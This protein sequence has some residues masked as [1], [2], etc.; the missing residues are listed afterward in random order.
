MEVKGHVSYPEPLLKY[1]SE[2]R[3]IGREMGEVTTIWSPLKRHKERGTHLGMAEN[4]LNIWFLAL[5]GWRMPANLPGE[6][7]P[8]IL[9]K[10][11]L[12][13]ISLVITVNTLQ[14]PSL[15]PLFRQLV[16]CWCYSIH[17]P[18]TVCICVVK[19]IQRVMHICFF[20][21]QQNLTCFHFLILLSKWIGNQL[22]TSIN[23]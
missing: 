19:G 9:Q 10:F 13:C 14:G 8:N 18:G 17:S 7:Q 5:S 1:L 12:T 23:M 21:K 4:A 16:L 3:S 11:V 6:P 2:I 20:I 15:I 22:W